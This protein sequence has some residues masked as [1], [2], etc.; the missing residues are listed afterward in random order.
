M[1]MVK[2]K[3]DKNGLTSS[4]RYYRRNKEKILTKQKELQKTEWGEHR[5]EVNRKSYWKNHDKTLEYHRKKSKK[6]RIK[7]RK[8]IYQNLGNK[9]YF[10]GNK[11]NLVVHETN[12][13]KHQRKYDDAR[14]IYKNLDK[15]SFV[16]LCRMCHSKIH[17][18]MKYTTLTW[19]EI[20]KRKV[21]KT[22]P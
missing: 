21:L 19:D 3:R 6:Y 8:L 16:I 15:F 2:S 10:C 13:V 7:Y 5:R 9:C 17:W 20:K 1:V 11:N 22:T 4:Q 18:I 12:G 14:T